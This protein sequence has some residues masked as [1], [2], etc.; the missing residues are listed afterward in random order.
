MPFKTKAIRDR[1]RKRIAQQVR[2]GEPCCFCRAPISLALR[3]PDPLSFTVHHTIPS[4]RGG[5]DDYE[6]L[7]PSHAICNKRAGATG[8]GSIGRNSGVLG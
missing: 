1:Q 5:G 8:S 6:L 7:A 2:A 3:Y 4:S